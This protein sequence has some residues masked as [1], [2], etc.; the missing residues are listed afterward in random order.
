MRSWKLD[1]FFLLLVA[2]RAAEP[3][4]D[5]GDPLPFEGL[6]TIALAS[7]D[8]DGSQPSLGRCEL[9]GDDGAAFFVGSAVWST[10]PK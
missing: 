6:V 5:D 7:C 3:V 10:S 4:T 1:V 2:A 8:T 9:D